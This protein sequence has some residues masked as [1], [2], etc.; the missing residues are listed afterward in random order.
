MRGF[1]NRFFLG[2]AVVI[3]IVITVGVVWFLTV[4]IGGFLYRSFSRIPQLAEFPSYITAFIGL[5]VVVLFIYICGLLANSL[6]GRQLLRLIEWFLQK[7]PLIR[8]LYSAARQLTKALFVDRSAFKKAALV[9]FP[10]KGQYTIGFLTNEKGFKKGEHYLVSLFIP[11]TPNITTGYYIL[12]DRDELLFPPITTE[13]AFRVLI[14]GG[15]LQIPE[16][17]VKKEIK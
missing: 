16:C 12:V 7:V 8:G 9:E 10:R 13:E 3:P 5:L 17:E 14:S 11:T 6:I 4:R 1:K 15:V 2:L